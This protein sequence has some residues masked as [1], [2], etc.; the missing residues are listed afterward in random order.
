MKIELTKV[1]Q[2]HVRQ[3][4]PNGSSWLIIAQVP[5]KGPQ[6]GP[7]GFSFS[8]TRHGYFRV[9]FYIDCGDK[10]KNKALY[11]KLYAYKNTIQAQLENVPSPLE[12][13]RMDDK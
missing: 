1:A 5:S 2:F 9:Q 4:P 8:L 7:L 3:T 10:E 6:L 11:D 12:W 13:E